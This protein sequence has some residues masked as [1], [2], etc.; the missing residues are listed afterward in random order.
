LFGVVDWIHVNS[1]AAVPTT[2]TSITM[3]FRKNLGFNGEP[4]GSRRAT[5]VRRLWG[6]YSVERLEHPLTV[7]MGLGLGYGRRRPPDGGAAPD[8]GFVT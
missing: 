1:S 3:P 4:P 7:V 5:T 6:E 8:E 2:S